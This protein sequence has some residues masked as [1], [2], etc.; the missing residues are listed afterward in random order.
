MRERAT[1]PEQENDMKQ[2]I[3]YNAT[4]KNMISK[5]CDIDTAQAIADTFND[6]PD[7][8]TYK[9]REL[10]TDIPADLIGWYDPAADAI[11]TDAMWDQYAPT[12]G[13]MYTPEYVNLVEDK[14]NRADTYNAAAGHDTDARTRRWLAQ[15]GRSAES[16]MWLIA[17]AGI[18]ATI[19]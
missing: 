1:A 6:D 10:S 9:I 3:V 13:D 5:P 19:L 16:V 14:L 2:Y 4:T 18:F 8:Y 17:V 7:G 15:L 11:D 12:G